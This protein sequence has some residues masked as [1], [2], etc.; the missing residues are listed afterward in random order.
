MTWFNV[1]VEPSVLARTGHVAVCL[2]FRHDDSNPHDEV[3][4]FGGGDNEGKF[5]HDLI[6]LSIPKSALA[7]KVTFVTG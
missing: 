7:G 5:F 6:S 1:V 2:P 4:L 3:L